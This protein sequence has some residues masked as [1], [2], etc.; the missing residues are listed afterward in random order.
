[1]HLFGPTSTD[2]YNALHTLRTIRQERIPRLRQD[3]ADAEQAARTF[4]DPHLNDEGLQARRK[5]M[6][7]QARAKLAAALDRLEAE[8]KQAADTIRR[9]AQEATA[10]AGNANEQLLAEMRQSKAWERARSLLEAGRTPAEVIAS[11]DVDTLRALRAELP[12]YLAA[13]VKRKPGL[14]NAYG[15]TGEEFDPAPV[16]RTIDMAMAE[17]VGGQEGAALRAVLDLA[18]VEP[19]LEVTFKGLRAEAAGMVDSM[20][21]MSNA[22]EAKYA[23]QMAARTLVAS[24]PAPAA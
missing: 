22:M 1:M 17:K 7:D 4:T 15:Q 21:R 3:F 2:A 12:T 19:G 18:T 14:R 6:L 13:Q 9:V 16:L 24:D 10:P 23:E 11:A 5:E 20:A 8:A